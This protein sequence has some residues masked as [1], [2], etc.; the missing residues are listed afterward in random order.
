MA[1]GA[2]FILSGAVAGSQLVHKIMKP[3]MSIPHYSLYLDQVE[4]EFHE[5]YKIPM[6]TPPNGTTQQHT[7][8]TPTK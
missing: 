5:K 2:V 3:D 4:E 8:S 6:P 7:T 1:I